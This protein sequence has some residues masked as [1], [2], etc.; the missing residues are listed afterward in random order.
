MEESRK[1]QRFRST[2]AQLSRDNE[3]LTKRRLSL[4]EEYTKSTTTTNEDIKK[5][6]ETVASQDSRIL[7]LE[8]LLEKAKTNTYRNANQIASLQ[9]QVDSLLQMQ[10]TLTMR[11]SP[12]PTEVAQSVTQSVPV[13]PSEVLPQSVP[14]S[15]SDVSWW[16]W[17]P[18]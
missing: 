15:T 9:G 6:K 13:M 1:M 14:A 18:W 16:P 10:P 3:E 7:M 4:Q 5:L 17:K 8:D 2:I 12:P 11:I